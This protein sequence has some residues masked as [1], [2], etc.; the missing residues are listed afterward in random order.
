MPLKQTRSTNASQSSRVSSTGQLIA[1]IASSYRSR[2]PSSRS[3]RSRPPSP[4]QHSSPQL[5]F[6]TPGIRITSREIHGTPRDYRV[7]NDGVS[8][9]T[10]PQTPAHLPESRHR[11]RFHPSWTAPTNRTWQSRLSRPSGHHDG[12]G[13]EISEPAVDIFATPPR[14]RGPGRSDSPDGMTGSGFQGLYGGQENGD[15]ERSWL[16][17]VRFDNV[18]I[19]LWGLR[20]ARTDGRILHNT[21][22]REDWRSNIR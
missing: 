22:E 3:P 11:S 14:I 8:P 18:E 1:R 4:F 7:Y 16:E 20:D 21:P 15:D 2:S 9:N 5:A 12:A 10:Q 13:S 19:R 6:P 17:G